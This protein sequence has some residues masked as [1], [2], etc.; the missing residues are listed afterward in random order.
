MHN[1][2]FCFQLTQTML[3]H[4]H[5][6]RISMF[7]FRERCTR[8]RANTVFVEPLWRLIC[9]LRH[10]S[11]TTT[12]VPFFTQLL[13]PGI[14]KFETKSPS[15]SQL[16][17]H[18][19]LVRKRPYQDPNG[20]V[21]LP[22]KYTLGCSWWRMRVYRLWAS[23]GQRSSRNGWVGC[24]NRFVTNHNVQR[25]ARWQRTNPLQLEIGCCSTLK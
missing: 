6:Y 4:V 23:Y 9:S 10:Q 2:P 25:S 18:F 11:I 3:K 19:F 5:Y 14:Y 1:Q 17:E 7:W 8:V 16:C 12:P 21:T 15:L 22:W 24:E 20:Q 13:L